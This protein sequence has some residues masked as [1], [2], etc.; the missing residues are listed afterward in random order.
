MQN[1]IALDVSCLLDAYF[2][3]KKEFSIKDLTKKH[4][5]FEYVCNLF[6][7]NLAKIKGG[8]NEEEKATLRY[9]YNL[10]SRYS[11]M[12]HRFEKLVVLLE[13][14][15]FGKDFTEIQKRD[16]RVLFDKVKDLA[17]MS[18]CMLNNYLSKDTNKCYYLN[19]VV[20]VD[21]EVAQIKIEIKKDMIDAY[22]QEKK[23]AGNAEKFGRLINETEQLGEHFTAIGL[24]ML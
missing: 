5:E 3:E 9:F 12:R 18:S 20:Q 1:Q 13:D 10:T 2:N 14:T 22:R 11:S 17:Q 15:N 6:D 4:K 16:A 21:K 24:N 23:C 19:N 8:M 7:S